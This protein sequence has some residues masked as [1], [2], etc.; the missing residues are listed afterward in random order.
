MTSPPLADILGHMGVP[1]AI[2]LRHFLERFGHPVTVPARIAATT[3]AASIPTGTTPR[4]LACELL[5]IGSRRA[6]IALIDVDIELVVDL[7][8]VIDPARAIAASVVSKQRIIA[9]R[10]TST[11]D[12]PMERVPRVQPKLVVV[13]SV[14]IAKVVVSATGSDPKVRLQRR[15]EQRQ[16]RGVVEARANVHGLAEVE[17][18]KQRSTAGKRV[19][20]VAR[21]EHIAAGRPEIT[22]GH[23]HPVVVADRPIAGTPGVA[24]LLPHPAAGDP[25]MLGRRRLAHRPEFQ[26]FRRRLGDVLNFF[27][28]G[29]HPGSRDPLIL[30]VG[31][32]P[33]ARQ[34]P[35]PR[36][37]L[38]PHAADP[39][40]VRAVVIPEPVAGQ[41]L[42]VVASE[43]LLGRNLGNQRRWL[44][45]DDHPLHWF[46]VVLFRVR[47]MDR[48]A[49]QLF[50]ISVDVL[51]S[52]S[53]RPFI[54]ADE[55]RLGQGTSHPDVPQQQRDHPST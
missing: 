6:T 52:Q 26:R 43:L 4:S 21:Q 35:L 19:I 51:G 22:L 1:R 55:Q 33:V 53:D 7:L 30:T 29:H 40:E 3:A 54:P 32:G 42:D 46:L 5:V 34:P 47:L 9:P 20:P 12:A 17:R 48:P 24:V 10:A 18:R 39:D 38:A 25:E 23:P 41:P 49:Q 31:F 36:R 11:A 13:H 27:L 50:S 28:I 2:A 15:S 45:I 8:K 37:D 44:T 14:E 16:P